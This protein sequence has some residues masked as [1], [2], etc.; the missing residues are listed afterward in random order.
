MAMDGL[1]RF[2][3]NIGIRI[4]VFN[5]ILQFLPWPILSV[6]LA[7]QFLRFVFEEPIPPEPIT[8]YLPRLPAEV[9]SLIASKL[10]ARGDLMG[11]A[12]AGRTTYLSANQYLYQH[13]VLEEEDPSADVVYFRRRLYRLDR[14]L[15]AQ[16]ASYVQ[17]ADFS[18]YHDIDDKMLLRIITKCVNLT[19]F[20]LPATQVPL[21]TNFGPRLFVFKRPVFL[22]ETL[23]VPMYD[24]LTSLTW[25]GPFIPFR[26]LRAHS[27]R[28]HLF[29]F[30]NLKSLAMI[31]RPDSISGGE[32]I[33]CPNTYAALDVGLL[34]HDLDCIA[35]SCPMLEELTFPFWE[36]VYS[37][38]GVRMFS[39]FKNLQKL[40]F[41]AIDGPMKLCEYGKGLI[42]FMYAADQAGIHVSFDN[43]WRDHV[44]ILSLIDEMESTEFINLFPRNLTFGPVGPRHAPWRG[45]RGI[46]DR[47]EWLS[48]P[49]N[50][51]EITLRW[52]ITADDS[53]E[54]VFTIPSCFTVVEFY[55]DSH[56]HRREAL[57]FLKF[58]KRMMEAIEF[59]NVER[60]QIVMNCVDAFYLAFPFFWQYQGDRVLTLDVQR[61]VLSNGYWIRRQWS[62]QR[63]AKRDPVNVELE[64]LTKD[65]IHVHPARL[66]ERIMATLL[67]QGARN[68]REISC[69]F[70]DRKSQ[71]Q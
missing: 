41:L 43:S 4:I 32:Y 57:P 35:N 1:F 68:V 3:W 37:M 56:V 30:P 70:H 65:G 62:I 46:L 5:L 47:L 64:D 49:S 48:V 66:F 40:H 24:G 7:V 38:G 10:S 27:G 25:T 15:T 53:S 55:F 36:T 69:A 63:G 60:I 8:I 39:M 22:S 44:D 16:N 26:G 50:D 54:P 13:I 34:A 71:P 21:E 18:S 28:H 58:R 23:S 12:I 52:P 19:S 9:I 2:A 11:M 51:R 33:S 59:E 42:K 31:Y 67:F 45:R 20:S 6:S 61:L 14:C 17:K 29:L